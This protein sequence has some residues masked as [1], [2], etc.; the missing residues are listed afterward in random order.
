MVS[1]ASVAVALVKVK[2]PK[3]D[4]AAS[5]Q[6]LEQTS[7]RSPTHSA[8]DC[9]GAGE[10]LGMSIEKCQFWVA[11]ASCSVQVVPAMPTVA[12]IASPGATVSSIGT[13]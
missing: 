8:D 7:G 1:V 13:S 4:S 9:A 6:V 3:F 12:L 10:G 11:S 2:L 5:P